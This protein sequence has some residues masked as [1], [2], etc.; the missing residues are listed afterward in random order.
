MFDVD[1]CLKSNPDVEAA[2]INPLLH[3]LGTGTKEGRDPH[4]L[5]DSSFYLERNRDVAEAG[6]TPLGQA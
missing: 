4:P 5:F 2:G 3:Y 6:I 1:Y